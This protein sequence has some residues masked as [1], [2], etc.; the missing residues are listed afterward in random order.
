MKLKFYAFFL[1][2]LIKCWYLIFSTFCA[3]TYDWKMFRFNFLSFIVNANDND[4]CNDEYYRIV[5]ISMLK[6]MAK[7]MVGNFLNNKTCKYFPFSFHYFN[8]NIQLN[9]MILF[10]LDFQLFWCEL[11][12]HAGGVRNGLR[13]RRRSWWGGFGL[14]QFWRCQGI[15]GCFEPMAKMVIVSPVLSFD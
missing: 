15:I 1:S 9:W 14:S 6:E 8:D 2:F 13:M 12:I 5:M 10:A 4:D 7:E 11:E 3:H